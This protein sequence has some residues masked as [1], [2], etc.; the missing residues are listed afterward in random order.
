MA[1]GRLEEEI[2]LYRQIMPQ[3]SLQYEMMRKA[4]TAAMG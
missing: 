1:G 2:T 3:S 4:Y